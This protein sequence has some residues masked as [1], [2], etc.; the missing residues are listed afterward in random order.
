MKGSKA[1]SICVGVILLCQIFPAGV[2]TNVW[3]T[4]VPGPMPVNGNSEGPVDPDWRHGALQPFLPNVGQLSDD[5]IV[6]YMDLPRGGLAF[7]R[8]RVLINMAEVLGGGPLFAPHSV[9]RGGDGE[10]ARYPKLLESEVRGCTVALAFEG[11][12][13]VEPSGVRG[14]PGEYNYL[15]G[16][17]P[18]RWITGVRGSSQVVYE[19][20]YQGID[21]VYR[22]TADGLKYEFRLAPGADPDLISVRLAGHEGLSVDGGDLV[23]HT[24]LGDIRDSGLRVFYEDAPLETIAARFVVTGPDRYGFELLDRDPGRA[25]VIDPLVWSTF[26]GT[27]GFEWG[28]AIAVDSEGNSL[29]TGFT[30]VANFPTT[31]GVYQE[32]MVGNHE[33][34]V[35]KLAANGSSLVWST[36]L[37]G[38]GDE[39]AND[40]VVD[41][42][43]NVYVCGYTDSGDFPLT[44][45]PS[46]P[47]PL[48]HYEVFVS[49]LSA[50]GRSLL[51]STL[52]GGSGTDIGNALAVDDEGNVYV[53]G[54]TQSDDFNTTSDA[55]MHEH[56]G[57]WDAMAFKLDPQF[58]TL[59][60]S[61]YLGGQEDDEGTGI[62][63]GSDGSAYVTG[64]TESEGFPN[65]TGAFQ[66]TLGRATVSGF[67]TKLSPRGDAFDSS[68]FLGDDGEQMGYG[69]AL[70][71]GGFVHVAGYTTSDDFPVTS[72]AYQTT[73]G[74]TTSDVFVTKMTSDLSR[75]VNSTYIGGEGWEK[76][77]AMDIDD[78]GNLL[79][80]G[81]TDSQDYPTTDGA[82]QR[83][84][85]GL[86]DGFLTKLSANYSELEYS[87]FLGADDW[88]I[89]YSVAA[90]GT[91]FAYIT[92]ETRSS[93]FPTTPGALQGEWGGSTDG[94]V[95]KVTFDTDP[96]HADAGP[97]VVVDQH[98]TVELNGS[99]SSDTNGLVNWTWSF[100]YGGDDV[101]LYGPVVSWTFDDAGQYGVDLEVTDVG[102]HKATD[103][104]VVTVRDI[105]RPLADAGQNRTIQQNETVVL[106]GSGS[107]DNVGVVDWN[108]SFLYGGHEV[109]LS[110]EVVQ[111]TFGDAGGF[112]VTLNV[113]DAEGNWD[114]DSIVVYV[115]DI[116]SPVAD[117][118]PDI[119]LGQHEVAE[120]NG[121]LSTDNVEIV[122][123]TWS[124]EYDGQPVILYGPLA[125]FTFH[126]VG[127]YEVRLSVE[128]AM[129][130]QAFDTTEVH[131]GDTTIPL[132]DAGPDQVVDQGTMVEFDGTASSDNVGISSYEWSFEYGGEAQTLSG[133]TSQFRFDEAGTYLVTLT[134]TDAVGNPGIDAV[135]VTVVDITEPVADAGEDLTVDQHDE[136]ILDGSGS[137]DD[138]GVALWAW[139]FEYDGAP[140]ELEGQS[141]P[142]TFDVAGE[143]EVTLTVQ[144]GA[145][146]SDSATITV[147]VRDITPPVP[148]LGGDITVDQGDTV[149]LDGTASSD[150]VGVV[151]FTWTFEY[152][153]ATVTLTGALQEHTFEVPST[154]E[155][156]LSVTDGAGNVASDSIVLRVRDTI[157]PVPVVDG[158][159][160]AKRGEAVVLDASRSTDNVGIA[161]YTWTFKD[162]GETVTLEGERVEYT[163]DRAGDYDVVLSLEDADGNVAT[164]DINVTVRG[165][166]WIWVALLAIIVIVAALFLLS[167]KRGSTSGAD[168]E[169]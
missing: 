76:A 61:T 148:A 158:H 155:I 132:A 73:I 161:K 89:A 44:G 91:L 167:R 63:V 33:V 7:G 168:E 154:Y 120:L 71:D 46:T 34:F 69:I 142:F 21:L 128:D 141:P 95:A 72:G 43:G 160:T 57:G 111:F 169:G 67:V 159:L 16:S 92:G 8:D 123:W 138:V 5:D 121:S 59:S 129:G 25:I 166:V 53:T 32:D 10:I 60:Y 40:V 136:V 156:T 28:S 149:T 115:R 41:D 116:T 122:N 83:R 20:L 96:P 48:T 105:T 37:G 74:G 75:V 55:A 79:V 31:T 109:V 94:F 104:M 64:S 146:N 162:G 106:D 15:M 78:G 119:I 110:G 101:V 113:S 36:F 17:D 30:D 23:I 117:A 14:L 3:G 144:D 29:I 47:P 42:S 143:Y 107:S 130:N 87:T 97:D 112:N 135:T 140:V 24:A 70:D 118:G 38:H 12:S 126:V 164:K 1:L 65:T 108:W 81:F 150:N 139:T 82:Q 145:G 19:D 50:N 62:V 147:T 68:T 11:A 133:E 93:Y 18:A 137:H 99:G 51:A 2:A 4:D 22:S 125:W 54:E 66:P 88:D 13:G 86:E 124:F 56:G 102:G 26:L 153:G 114:T 157:A 49:K 58:D 6:M 134:V 77:Y 152:E 165:G 85:M 84:Y 131:V 39:F 80:C 45:I 90:H 100:V 27:Q 151:D 163:F 9:K 103:A 127:V 98:Q 52:V 35:T